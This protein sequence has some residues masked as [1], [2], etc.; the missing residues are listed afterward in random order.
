M[1]SQT[2]SHSYVANE[3]WNEKNWNI[4][5]I[6][7]YRPYRQKYSRHETFAK[8][9]NWNLRGNSKHSQINKI[10]S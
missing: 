1:F 2:F 7:K 5:H 3:E 8:A 10:K 4:I 6:W 9:K